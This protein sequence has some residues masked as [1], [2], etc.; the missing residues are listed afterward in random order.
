MRKWKKNIPEGTRDILF[1]DCADKRY[2]ENIL[3]KV[4][5]DRG[6][7]EI[8]TPTLEFYDVF[9]GDNIWIEQEKLYKLFDNRGRIMVL[10]PDMTTPAARL[11]ATKLRDSY[12][13]IKFCYSAN[14]FRANENLNGK[15]NEFTQSGVEILGSG[16]LKA[17][18][19]VIA[20]AMKAMIKAGITNFKLE[21]GQIDFF[22]GIVEN[23]DLE[24]EEKESIRSFIENKNFGALKDFLL[25][26]KAGLSKSDMEILNK[27]P[28]LFGDIKVL[29]TARKLLNQLKQGDKIKQ[30]FEA[31]NNL[32]NIYDILVT[33]GFKD[34][35]TVD[36]GMVHHIDYYTGLIFRAYIDEAGD[37][38]LSGGRYD[39]LVKNFGADIPA[40]GFAI[41]VDGILE[42]FHKQGRKNFVNINADY[43]IHYDYKSTDIANK[44]ADRIISK[45]F[46]CEMSFFSKRE[47]TVEYSS[48]KGIKNIIFIKDESTYIYDVE[49]KE[50]KEFQL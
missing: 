23:L 22:K 25:E 8:V 2:I 28:A 43:I 46:A 47:E 18:I 41:N 6:F 40:T 19:E 21:L 13:P 27:L 24:D 5:L 32:E 31:L 15:K 20:T 33:M 42:Y 10:R 45:G 48:K 14:V 35:L 7:V 38:I 17:D 34:Y 1:Q 29:D 44:L 37:E 36:L 11:A 3:K 16:E 9:D 4:Y 39:K 49:S 30:A 12:Y 26:R 50:E